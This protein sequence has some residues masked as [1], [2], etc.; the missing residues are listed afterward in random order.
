MRAPAR[1]CVLPD[2]GLSR[3]AVFL[4]RDG[5]I[6]EDVGYLNDVSQFRMFPFAAGAI[7]RLND[8]NLPVIV[9]TNQ[10]GVGRGFF[11][12]SMVQTVHREM[13]QQLAAAGAHLTAIYYCPH[14]SEDECE[15]RK[16]KPGMIRQAASEHGVDLA[17]SFVV[18]DRYGDVELAQANGGQG[19]LVRTGY[20]DEDL[21]VNGAGWIRQPDFVA[22]DLTDA[23]AWILK[24]VGQ[25]R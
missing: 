7:R 2:A 18:G 3:P 12:E 20:G 6:S 23:V 13:V 25:T 4:D 8:A 9:V 22:D 5:T 14:T 21:R 11:A 19:V 1:R 16:P 24:S 17:R 10:S 15:C